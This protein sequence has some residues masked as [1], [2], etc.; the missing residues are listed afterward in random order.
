MPNYV[1]KTLKKLKHPNPK[2]P[3]KA[4]HTWNVPAYGKQPQLA[5][6]DNSPKLPD[7]EKK[8]IQQIVGSFLYYARAI[9]STILPALSEI[10]ALQSNPTE[11]TKKKATMLLDY[12]ATNPTAKIRYNASDMI[13]HVESDAAY[14]IAPNAKS[15]IAGYYYMG[16]LPAKKE[17]TIN[18]AILV[19]CRYLRHVVAS[20]AEAEMSGLFHNA[21]VG[22]I[23]RR[24]LHYL[25]H[26]Q[27][28]TPLKTDNTTASNFVH[29]N[30]N[31]R[32]SKTWDMRFHWLRDQQ[33]KKEFKIYWK[34]GNDKADPNHG[35]YFTKHHITKH[36]RAVRSCYVIDK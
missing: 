17:N 36:H 4:P 25:G 18:G 11:N 22:I 6:I 28:A 31:L 27:P 35:D 32:R 2:K 21:Q 1:A 7:N 10:S 8:R 34:H 30:M 16:N 13:L 3:V 26:P 12:L 33:T 9:D 29:H 20:A 14:L 19:E 15:R 5:P 23:A 24:I